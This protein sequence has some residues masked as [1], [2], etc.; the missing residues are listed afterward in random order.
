MRLSNIATTFSAIPSKEIVAKKEN[1]TLS[2]FIDHLKQNAELVFFLPNGDQIPAHFHITE[3]GQIT[4]HFIDC[5][6]TER[7]E[8]HISFQIWIDDDVSH[9][10]TADKL[11][12][13][14]DLSRG[15]ISDE[16][17]PLKA[18]YQLPNEYFG[19]LSTIGSYEVNWE[20]GHFVLGATQ[21]DCLAKEKCGIPPVKT[22]IK[23]SELNYENSGKC[24]PKSGCC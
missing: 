4:K 23:L 21:T 11:L 7:T 1:M 13:I 18:E 16:N 17:L 14:I 2:A 22:K 12:K 6:G 24:N 10:L 20:H 19:L 15:L 3:V 9:R 8:K 5:G